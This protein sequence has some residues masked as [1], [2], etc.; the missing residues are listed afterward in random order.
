MPYNWC[1]PGAADIHVLWSDRECKFIFSAAHRSTYLPKQAILDLRIWAHCENHI[2]YC[3]VKYYYPVILRTAVLLPVHKEKLISQSF[4]SL[5]CAWHQKGA[6]PWPP[7]C[8][9][10]NYACLQECKRRA[11]HFLQSCPTAT[12]PLCSKNCLL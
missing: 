9:E 4:M 11:T 5:L 3:T 7:A 2:N 1:W 8:Q 6:S 12:S 10:I